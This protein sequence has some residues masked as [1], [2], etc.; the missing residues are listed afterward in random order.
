MQ[1]FSRI[2]G[3]VSSES[4]CCGSGQHMVTLGLDGKLYPC[5]RFATN[6]HKYSIGDVVAG[7][8]ERALADLINSFA[9]FKCQDCSQNGY[10]PTCF[11]SF[12]DI[13][14]GE[15]R[16]VKNYCEMLK[17]EQRIPGFYARKVL[18]SSISAIKWG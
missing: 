5:H 12:Y 1:G 11:A 8:D 16:A 9:E 10:C 4:F 18:E 15:F 17:A 7:L 2:K 13:N 3:K 6:T 14:G